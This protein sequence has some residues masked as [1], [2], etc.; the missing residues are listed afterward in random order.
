[1]TP[2]GNI[3]GPEPWKTVNCETFSYWDLWFVVVMAELPHGK[4]E[5]VQLLKRK[6]T[7][8]FGTHRRDVEAKLSH[9]LDL[10]TRL[11]SAGLMHDDLLEDVTINYRLRRRANDKVMRRHI[12]RYAS[13]AMT[14]TPRKLLSGRAM[15]GYWDRF[16]VSPAEHEDAFGHQFVRPDGYWDYSATPVVMSVLDSKWDFQRTLAR[17]A[18]ERVAVDRLTLTIIVGL[19]EHIDDDG[20]A[21]PVFDEVIRSYVRDVWS[22]EVDPEVILRDGIEFGVWEDYGLTWDFRVFLDTIPKEHLGLAAKIF[23]ETRAEL[24]VNGLDREH[25]VV[26]DLWVTFA[27]IHEQ[28]DDFVWLSQRLRGEVWSHEKRAAEMIEVARRLGRH[29][30]AAMVMSAVSD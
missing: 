21:A 26:M 19:M 30:V 16:P 22:A 15:R 6:A 23:A 13:P 27:L 18:A 25:G 4:W 20:D 7:Q 24:V 17:S 29:D 14:N 10:E 2:T 5:F 12:D 11:L 1:M 8:D 9:L 28:V 3:Y